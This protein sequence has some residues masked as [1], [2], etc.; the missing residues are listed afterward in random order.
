M[1]VS[2]DVSP[3]LSLVVTTSPVPSNPDLQM[4]LETLHSLRTFGQLPLHRLHAVVVTDGYQVADGRQL[5]RGMIEPTDVAPYEEFKTRLRAELDS[6]KMFA[7]T[8]FIEHDQRFGFGTAALK[9]MEHVVTPLVL[10]VQHDWLLV[11]QVDIC[12][13]LPLFNRDD[14]KYLTFAN[15]S[16][17]SYLDVASWTL[18]RPMESMDGQLPVCKSIYPLFCFCDRLHLARTDYWRTVVAKHVPRGPNKQG[19]FPEAVISPLI[20]SDV[21]RAGL[22]GH[23]PWGTWLLHGKEEYVAHSHGR[24]FRTEEQLIGTGYNGRRKGRAAL[25]VTRA[26]KAGRSSEDINSA[27]S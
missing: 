15:K 18:R 9:A 21:L 22:D 25:D 27:S 11:R 14:V 7:S 1:E 13:L 19:N 3:A 8:T 12:E 23:R 26:V 24:R 20:K 6:T 16:N 10:V 5:R 2:A 17:A 4:L